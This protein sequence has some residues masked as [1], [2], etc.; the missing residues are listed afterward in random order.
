MDDIKLLED[1]YTKYYE[2]FEE[3]KELDYLTIELF[4]NEDFGIEDIED[5]VR[6]KHFLNELKD[7]IDKKIN[8]VYEEMINKD[9]EN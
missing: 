6:V 5:L 1:T 9:F 2:V 3:L 7:N 4:N 8:T